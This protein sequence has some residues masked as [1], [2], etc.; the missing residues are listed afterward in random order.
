[1]FKCVPISIYSGVNIYE[2]INSV[3]LAANCDN[4]KQFHLRDPLFKKV[5][6]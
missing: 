2:K 6:H 5:S 3:D 1:M 4:L